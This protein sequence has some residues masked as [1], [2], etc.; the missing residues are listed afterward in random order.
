MLQG[1]DLEASDA[2]NSLH[3]IGR[4]TRETAHR[5]HIHGPPPPPQGAMGLGSDRNSSAA[6][7]GYYRKVRQVWPPSTTLNDS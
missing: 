3:E 4:N 6:K 7:I 1:A 2:S 5:S